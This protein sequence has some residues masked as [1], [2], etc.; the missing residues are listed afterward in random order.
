MFTPPLGGHS[1]VLHVFVKGDVCP[2]TGFVQDYADISALVKP[3][4]EQLD[5]HHLGTDIGGP[6]AWY[7]PFSIYPSSENILLWLGARLLVH[8]LDWS[9]LALEETCTSYAE[10]SREEFDA[11]GR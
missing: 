10:L 4:I 1:W 6:P 9:R 11:K 3:I 8:G 5:H 2:E 7:G